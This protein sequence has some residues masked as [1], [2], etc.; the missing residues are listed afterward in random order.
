MTVILNTESKI[1]ALEDSI[2]PVSSKLRV[3]EKQVNCMSDQ[4]DD[5]EIRI[6]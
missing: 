1:S 5:L 2:D 4:S 6:E 3:L